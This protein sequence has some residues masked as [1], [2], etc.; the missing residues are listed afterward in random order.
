MI[1]RSGTGNG[2]CAR[3]APRRSAH[4]RV[5]VGKQNL[6]KV[7]IRADL[8]RGASAVC[9]AV[10]GLDA[11]EWFLERTQV[12]FVGP[13]RPGLTVDLPIRLGDCLD[14]EHAVLAAFLNTLGPA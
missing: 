5:P 7:K 10:I 8:I 12:D 3:S 14:V 4:P 1:L 11:L 2:R 9:A 6:L 13:G